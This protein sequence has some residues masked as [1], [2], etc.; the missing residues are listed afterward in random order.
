MNKLIR[1]KDSIIFV[2][3]IERVYVAKNVLMFQFIS[4]GRGNEYSFAYDSEE[5]ALKELDIVYHTL[6]GC[7]DLL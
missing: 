4:A 3:K 6:I 1:F 7:Y 2:D 5:D